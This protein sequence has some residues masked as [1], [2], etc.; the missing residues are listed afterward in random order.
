MIVQF[1]IRICCAA[2]LQHVE[3]RV[4]FSLYEWSIHGYVPGGYAECRFYFL[5]WDLEQVGLTPIGGHDGKWIW[6]V[7]FKLVATE[8]NM[9][10]APTSMAFLVTM[11]GDL[12]E[13]VVSEH[14]R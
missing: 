1:L 14:K 4:V 10:G 7:S 6:R 11:D 12:I 13:P 2:V 3:Q 5:G 9:M 8:G